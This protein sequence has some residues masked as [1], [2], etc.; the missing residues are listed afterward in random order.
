MCCTIGETMTVVN[1]SEATDAVVND[2]MIIVEHTDT[3]SYYD[4]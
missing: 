4:I 3:H 2:V 1:G